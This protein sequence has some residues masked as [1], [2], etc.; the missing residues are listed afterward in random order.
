MISGALSAPGMR[1]L[2]DATR[3]EVSSAET[4]AKDTAGGA[5]MG[6]LGAVVAKVLGAA[7]GFVAGKLRGGARLGGAAR[8]PAFDF[9]PNPGGVRRTPKE[10]LELG[11][12]RK[13]ARAE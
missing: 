3:G 8:A 10:A 13:D 4:Y 2:H 9:R 11:W 1:A 12:S 7:F 6:V 5:L